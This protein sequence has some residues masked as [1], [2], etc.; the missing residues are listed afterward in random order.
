MLNVSAPFQESAV[1]D[2]Q[3]CLWSHQMTITLT[4]GALLIAFEI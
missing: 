2:I 1:I 3:L 4:G